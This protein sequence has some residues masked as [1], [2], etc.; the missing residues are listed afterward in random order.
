MLDWAFSLHAIPRLDVFLTT[1]FQSR[2]LSRFYF[3][4]YSTL[5]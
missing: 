3:R 5:P 1:E 4:R 2:Y